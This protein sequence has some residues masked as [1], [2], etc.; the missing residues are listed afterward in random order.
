[1]SQ[2]LQSSKFWAITIGALL[3]S[4]LYYFMG[5][6]IGLSNTFPMLLI[7]AY[8]AIGLAGKAEDIAKTIKSKNNE[9]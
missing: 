3:G 5:D 4:G 7:G 1:M 2:L 9:A 6:G 8:S